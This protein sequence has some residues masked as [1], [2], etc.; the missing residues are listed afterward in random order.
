MSSNI[1]FLPFQPREAFAEM[2][3]AADVNLVTLNTNSS[4]TSLPSKA[5]NIIASAP[6]FG[7]HTS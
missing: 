5:F 1:L 7:S 6:Y 3:A 2:L 4:Q